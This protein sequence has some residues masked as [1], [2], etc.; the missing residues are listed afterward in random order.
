MNCLTIVR[1]FYVFI[2]VHFFIV[3]HFSSSS[4]LAGYDNCCSFEALF[5]GVKQRSHFCLVEIQSGT[6]LDHEIENTRM[7]SGRIGLPGQDTGN[8]QGKTGE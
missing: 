6:S 3:L 8:P 2:L 1:F 7:G 4:K 5:C